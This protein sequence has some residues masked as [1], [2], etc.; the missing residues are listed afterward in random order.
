MRIVPRKMANA[1]A[2]ASK[3]YFADSSARRSAA[4]GIIE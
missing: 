1:I 4:S 2:L 3:K